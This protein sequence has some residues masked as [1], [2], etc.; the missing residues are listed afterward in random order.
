MCTLEDL[1]CF[2]LFILYVTV[3]AYALSN[4]NEKSYVG[5]YAL[6]NKNK[7]SY[8]EEDLLEAYYAG[9]KEAD[10]YEDLEQSALEGYLQ[11][12]QVEDMNETQLKNLISKAKE[13]LLRK[14]YANMIL[15]LLEDLY[16]K[17]FLSKKNN[18]IL[19]LF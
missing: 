3:G 17:I 8:D 7:K 18:R 13:C 1:V 9:M 11:A 15:G 12:K 10:V 14:T 4:R 6:S 16:T 19:L 5:A 2:I